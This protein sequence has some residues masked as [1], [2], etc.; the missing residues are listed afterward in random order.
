MVKGQIIKVASTGNRFRLD[1]TEKHKTELCYQFY[2]VK[3]TFPKEHI[4]PFKMLESHFKKMVKNKYI[5]I[6]PIS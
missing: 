3:N 2:P 4:Y 1:R 6:E 5:I